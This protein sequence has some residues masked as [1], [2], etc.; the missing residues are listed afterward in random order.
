MS[1]TTTYRQEVANYLFSCDQKLASSSCRSPLTS[2]IGDT[3]RHVTLRSVAAAAADSLGANDIGF[4]TSVPNRAEDYVC[5]TCGTFLLPQTKPNTNHAAS[6]LAELA[7]NPTTTTTTTTHCKISLQTMKRGRSRRRRASRCRAKELHNSSLLMKRAGST[8]NAQV[9]MNVMAQK[10]LLKVADSY[11][12]GDGK[13]KQCIVV[14]CKFCGSKRRRKGI[15]VSVKN[16][17]RKTEEQSDA[18]ASCSKNRIEKKMQP[19]TQTQAHKQVERKPNTIGTQIRD[20]TDFI[21]LASFGKSKQQATKK[22]TM[23][24]DA[25]LLQVGKKKKKKQEPKSKTSSSLMDFLSSLN[26]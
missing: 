17:R 10:E 25:P 20:N 16:T 26:D 19:Q 15:E 21:S 22:R 9:R 8:N 6:S 23:K 13:S 7:T 11:R 1:N 18:K 5:M 4:K 24:N 3:A 14:E 12:L 2:W